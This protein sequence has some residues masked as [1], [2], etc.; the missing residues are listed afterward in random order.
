MAV[1]VDTALKGRGAIGN[2]RNRFETIE[3]ERDPEVQGPART[4]ASTPR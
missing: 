4:W 1:L 2:P 3:V